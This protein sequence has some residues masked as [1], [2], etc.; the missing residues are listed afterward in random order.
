M[1]TPAV[2]DYS[3]HRS[4]AVRVWQRLYPDMFLTGS[5]G[6]NWCRRNQGHYYDI[7]NGLL[8]HIAAYFGDATPS[9]RRKMHIE[10]VF[11]GVT[12]VE[13]A[14]FFYLRRRIEES[15]YDGREYFAD[16]SGIHFTNPF[17]VSGAVVVESIDN[18]SICIDEACTVRS[19]DGRVFACEDCARLWH[20]TGRV[21]YWMRLQKRRLPACLVEDV[22]EVFVQPGYAFLDLFPSVPA[23]V[24][25]EKSSSCTSV[26]LYC[27]PVL[28]C[29]LID[30]SGFSSDNVL[31]VLASDFDCFDFSVADGYFAREAK[32]GTSRWTRGVRS[33]SRKQA[34]RRKS[35]CFVRPSF[36]ARMV[37]RAIERANFDP[38]FVA[39][40]WSPDLQDTWSLSKQVAEFMS[41]PAMVEEEVEEEVKVQGSGSCW[42][43]LFGPIEGVNMSTHIMPGLEDIMTIDLFLKCFGPRER[44]LRRGFGV[45]IY[46]H[47]SAQA[48]GDWHVEGC[49]LEP[50]EGAISGLELTKFLSKADRFRFRTIRRPVEPT[51]VEEVVEEELQIRGEGDCWRKFVDL[52]N[53][54]DRLTYDKFRSLAAGSSRLFGR[55]G[56][57]RSGRYSGYKKKQV[58]V[59]TRQADGHMHLE[60]SYDAPSFFSSLP[61]NHYLD[62]KLPE[63]H[64][65]PGDPPVRRRM[66]QRVDSGFS[67]PDEVLIGGRAPY[68]DTEKAVQVV[69][70]S[71]HADAVLSEAVA[72]LVDMF[73]AEKEIPF[74]TSK[75][76]ATLLQSEG[77][78]LGANGTVAHAHGAHKAME[79]YLY[80]HSYP[81]YFKHDQVN[82]FFTK[83][84]K[85]DHLRGRLP[86][87]VIALHNVV[88]DHKDWS[89]YGPCSLPATLEGD[90]ILLWDVGQF[91]N[92]CS[93]AA[94]LSRY[95]NIKR[96]YIS[97]VFAPES[98]FNKSSLY[99]E[100][101]DLKYYDDSVIYSMEGTEDG[102][103]EQPIDCSW[104]F[105]V[106]CATVHFPD[107]TVKFHMTPLQSKLTH[108]LVVADREPPKVDRQWWT[109]STPDVMEMPRPWLM[110]VKPETRAGDQ[111]VP[112]VLYW[113]L[114]YYYQSLKPAKRSLQDLVI[115]VR[116][117][118][119]SPLYAHIRPDTWAELIQ[120]VVCVTAIDCA[121]YEGNLYDA[122]FWAQVFRILLQRL[123]NVGLDDFFKV[124]QK[125]FVLVFG[126]FFPSVSAPL[127]VVF[128]AYE[129]AT[130]HRWSDYGLVCA[131]VVVSHFF[132][133]IGSVVLTSLGLGF[134]V[135]AFFKARKDRLRARLHREVKQ[136]IFRLE[137]ERHSIEV[138]GVADFDL[139]FLAGPLHSTSSIIDYFTPRCPKCFAISIGLCPDCL[140]KRRIDKQVGK[141]FEDLDED[142]MDLDVPDPP[143]SPLPASPFF[144]SLSSLHLPTAPPSPLLAPLPSPRLPPTPDSLPSPIAPLKS[145][146][147]S[148]SDPFASSRGPDS[149]HPD[150]LAALSYEPFKCRA[151]CKGKH[152]PGPCPPVHTPPARRP[153]ATPPDSR[154]VSPDFSGMPPFRPPPIP[155]IGPEL[156]PDHAKRNATSPEVPGHGLG[157]GALQQV[158]TPADPKVHG[159]CACSEH[160]AEIRVPGAEWSRCLGG[161]YHWGEEDS[162]CHFCPNDVC[163]VR[164]PGGV[165]GSVKFEYIHERMGLSDSLVH[166]ARLPNFRIFGPAAPNLALPRTCLLEAIHEAVDLPHDVIWDAACR[167]LP[168]DC[169]SGV[170]PAPGLDERFLHCV[171]LTLGRAAR[172]RGAGSVSGMV[173]F[174]SGGADEFEYTTK[175]GVPHWEY[176]GLKSTT[177]HSL[178]VR[179]TATQARVKPFLDSLESFRSSHGEPVKGKWEP[180]KVDKDPAKQ[181][182]REFANGTFGTI[183]KREGKDFVPGF[184]KKMDAMVDAFRGRSVQIRKISGCAGCGKSDPLKQFLRKE[185][186][187]AKGSLWM[188]S[189]PRILICGDWS[190]DLALPSGSK[191]LYTF[192]MALVRPCRVLIID[193]LSLMPPGYVDLI[194][195][196][197]PMISHVIL[198]GDTVQSKF[199]TPE[200]DCRLNEF[201]ND[202]ERFFSSGTVPYAFWTHRSP[203]V[204]AHRLGIPTTSPV[205][206]R[207]ERAYIFDARYPVIAA[208]NGEVSVFTNMSGKAR[209]IS[210]HQG[211]TMHTAQFHLT[212]TVLSRCS[213]EDLYSAFSRVTHRLI[214]VESLSGDY[215]RLLQSRP[216]VLA[217]LGMAPPVDFLGTFSHRLGACRIER[218]SQNKLDAI[219]STRATHVSRPVQ[220][221]SG[222]WRASGQYVDWWD[223]AP[224]E[225]YANLER[226]EIVK[227]SESKEQTF[228]NLDEHASTHLPRVPLDAI[229]DNVAETLAPKEE[230]EII[231]D[232]GMSCLFSDTESLLAN[233]LF[234]NQRQDDPVLF[235][236][237]VAKRLKRGSFEH[238]VADVRGSEWKSTLLRTVFLDYLQLPAQP[239][240][241]ELFEECINENEW[242][243]LT[244]KTQQTLLNNAGRADPDWYFCVVDHFIKTQL[245]GKMEALGIDG[246]AGQTLATCQDAII[247]LFG[248]MVKYMRRKI[249]G[250]FPPNLYCN[251]GK[252]NEDLSNWCREFW[253]DRESTESDYSGFDATQKG[254]SVGFE[255]GLMR[256]V[257]LDDAWT[258]LFADFS[259]YAETMPELYEFWKTHI[260]STV[261][262][263]KDLGRDTGEPGTFDF[264]TYFNLAL[265][266]LMYD[267]PRTLPICVG[268]DDMSANAVLVP[269]KLWKLVENNF[270]IIA[271]V[272]HTD[273]PSFCGYRL[274]KLGSFRNPYILLLK[275]AYHLAK[276]DAAAVD[277]NYAS[278]ARTAYVLRDELHTYC[279]WVELECLGFL[280]EYYHDVYPWAQRLFGAVSE[281]DLWRFLK[282]TGPLVEEW[283][284][285][286]EEYGKR[287]RKSLMRTFRVQQAVLSQISSY[288]L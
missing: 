50:R 72:G 195:T 67:E 130:A 208:T 133:K 144:S 132:G 282:S 5:D 278:E 51:M 166:R 260:V 65:F 275:T 34:P 89:R 142:A 140:E 193:E 218:L 110:D 23:F 60:S 211:G 220:R 163:Q 35:R 1:K 21:D 107:T 91:L 246:K 222:M 68:T 79:T 238:N 235:K 37:G 212:S 164:A 61:P 105:K 288:S 43:V 274:T 135:T 31:S 41:E 104:L 74:A 170:L 199:S 148:R 52:P 62:S 196:I 113:D 29:S 82:V 111:L 155:E 151:G 269:T 152:R 120:S 204:I 77:V 63:A 268:G 114:Y 188:L 216:L 174:K 87:N 272:E 69:K 30:I 95:P 169:T 39:R 251:C 280:L 194:L 112:R 242:S 143:D 2:I 229:V 96:V 209:T 197:N 121:P 178:G 244:K 240:D 134:V 182:A 161:Q 38:H 160:T 241:R 203:Q 128:L 249:M 108:H 157:R 168:A 273:R 225:T 205:A 221:A 102:A 206:G 54:P 46:T 266:I 9:F 44:R 158:L 80:R 228:I 131:D 271:K 117:Y 136:S 253:Q 10:G 201:P 33:I 154:P 97:S 230:R 83:Q 224:P 49:Y 200:P 254:D 189:V 171:Y 93:V 40:V 70:G 165:M 64:E 22:P 78:P 126:Y 156:L 99:P 265:V 279:S 236:S 232:D 15:V 19:S 270:L 100:Y 257:G 176:R 173:G 109:C 214:I 116:N 281:D 124:C 190:R 4:L 207:I 264:N 90:A 237:T 17:S 71:L 88:L 147:G 172:I 277:L 28:R 45:N 13:D 146:E 103:Y 184:T 20:A 56:G 145:G 3:Q 284:W 192:E 137:F 92:V 259:G 177:Q 123:Q 57:G 42:K 25:S 12:S 198:L 47:L 16:E 287:A 53:H 36:E 215:Q 233:S 248:P 48:D 250:A 58:L 8:V 187:F 127:H 81:S 180:Y 73:Q 86:A 159:P 18:C 85:F 262:G 186:K 185:K 106:S 75:S 94:L 223:R 129:I 122:S 59:I 226:V 239:F 24:L 32:V 27:P 276:G 138:K 256:H 217:I 175:N 66:V 11:D 255:V 213:D 26:V 261:I 7:L 115:K 119:K 179:P 234:P 14:A 191:C 252:N 125:V 153:P 231:S 167:V 84:S 118:R 139:P 245:K 76:L 219:R 6:Y 149:V 183:K 286:R 101:Y 210:G 283:S 267:P 181:L 162:A 150:L 258:A 243:K 141:L 285:E 247:L 55:G 263:P 202:A 227:P 98:S